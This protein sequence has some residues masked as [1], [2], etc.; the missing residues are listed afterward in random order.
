M[1]R[2]T[3]FPRCP[4]PNASLSRPCQQEQHFNRAHHPCLNSSCQARKFV[5]FNS[6]LDLQAHMV[7]EHGAEMSSRQQKDARRINAGFEFQE[8]SAQGS[9]GARRRPPREREPPPGSQPPGPGP[10]RQ[11]GGANNRRE[12]FGGQLTADGEGSANASAAPSRRQTPSPPPADMDPVTAEYVFI[13]VVC[14]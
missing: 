4:Y 14:A 13:T 5:V 9:S 6:M 3:I 10:G 2:I 12:R 7:D 8:I 11:G 1:V